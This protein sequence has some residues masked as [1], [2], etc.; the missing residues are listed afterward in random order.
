MNPSNNQGPPTGT[1]VP[2]SKN[3]VD[4][5]TLSIGPKPKP[6]PP[7]AK[8]KGDPKPDPTLSD[9]AQSFWPHDDPFWKDEGRN[10]LH[11]GFSPVFP[12]RPFEKAGFRAIPREQSAKKASSEGYVVER[13]QDKPSNPSLDR[14]FYGEAH[15]MREFY[16]IKSWQFGILTADLYS[17]LG[18]TRTYGGDSASVWNAFCAGLIKPKPQKVFPWLHKDA[19]YDLKE[20]NIVD[21]LENPVGEIVNAKPAHWSV[22]NPVLWR[23]IEI[24]LNWTERVYDL[25][26][27]NRHW[28]CK[29][30]EIVL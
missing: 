15:Q 9:W 27:I 10:Q 4:L 21:D 23:Y 11:S 22:D 3:P 2:S 8:A 6:K 12:Y 13:V 1:G 28:V 29:T 24:A 20:V 5:S 30:S 7:P 18:D 25:L 17:G 16:G 26:T 14:I 19:F